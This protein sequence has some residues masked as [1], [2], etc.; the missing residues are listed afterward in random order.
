[1]PSL[2]SDV[3]QHKLIV[4]GVLGRPIGP[5]F[6]GRAGLMRLI[7]SPEMSLIKSRCVT[8]QKSE[9]LIFTQRRKPEIPHEPSIYPRL[10]SSVSEVRNT[11]AVQKNRSW[12]SAIT[13]INLKE[14]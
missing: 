10:S 6:I 1:M 3:T 11:L 5:N 4:T 12:I 14:K 13:N 8:I 9:Y 7:V 2:F